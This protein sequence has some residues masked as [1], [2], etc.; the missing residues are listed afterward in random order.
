MKKIVFLL[1]AMTMTFMVFGQ[2]NVEQPQLNDNVNSVE[3]SE[4]SIVEQSRHDLAVMFEQA[5]AEYEAEQQ[6]QAERA[7]QMTIIKTILRALCIGAVY[8]VFKTLYNSIFKR[9]KSED[10]DKKK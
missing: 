5:Q 2:D 10:G 9:R 7:R 8:F 1:V 4:S 6:K 3:Q